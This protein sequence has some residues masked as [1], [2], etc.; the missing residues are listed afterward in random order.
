MDVRVPVASSAATELAWRSVR[1][2]VVARVLWGLPENIAADIGLVGPWR[3]L[4][5][6]CDGPLRTSTCIVTRQPSVRMTRSA[7]SAALADIRSQRTMPS[8]CGGALPA[9]SALRTEPA[10]VPVSFRPPGCSP[11]TD[12]ARFGSAVQ[13][14]SRAAS[15]SVT[16]SAV[17]VPTAVK[18][19]YPLDR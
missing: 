14:P 3:P 12:L 10:S 2:D 6:P 15:R 19:P 13:R 5:G 17:L 18:F 4:S 7:T 8:A 1:P 11:T 16:A 9:S